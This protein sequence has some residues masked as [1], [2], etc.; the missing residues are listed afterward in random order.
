MNSNFKLSGIQTVFFLS[1]FRL[2]DKP[3]FTK[4]LL[5]LTKDTFNDEPL[6]LPIPDDAPK[7]IPRIVLKSTDS[8]Y[9][10][11]ISLD[12][13][14]FN[15]RVIGEGVDLKFKETID[16]YLNN[17]EKIYNFLLNYEHTRISRIG[18]ITRFFIR[19]EEGTPTFIKNKFLKKGLF[20]NARSID[21]SENER[22]SLEPYQLNKLINIKSLKKRE[23]KEFKGLLT[24]IDINTIKEEDYDFKIGP[25]KKLLIEIK[26]YIMDND[27]PQ[28]IF[29]R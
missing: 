26:K 17:I 16:G 21:I 25:L 3:S 29:P 4:E 14:D 7:D 19:L 28:S 13:L 18:F 27:L 5:D 9:Y 6:I 20:P 15:F 24:E 1:D 23:E 22:I 2:T 12:K 8:S 10:A 11:N